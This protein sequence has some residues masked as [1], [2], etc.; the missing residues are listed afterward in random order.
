MESI[1]SQAGL[2][3]LCAIIRKRGAEMGMFVNG[4]W[5][6]VDP[7]FAAGDDSGAGQSAGAA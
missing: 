6:L 2:G 4:I 7:P 5:H 1:E 3:H